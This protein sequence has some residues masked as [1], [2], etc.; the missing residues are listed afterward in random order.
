MWFV[1]LVT[2]AGMAVVGLV[3]WTQASSGP[4][5]AKGDPSRFFLCLAAVVI[6]GVAVLMHYAQ[7]ITEVREDGLYIRFQPFHLSFRR[8]PLENLR[9]FCVKSYS[10]LKDYGGYGIRYGIMGKAYNISGNSGVNFTFRK[11]RDML[12]GSQR[13]EELAASVEWFLQRRG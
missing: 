9:R 8:I 1:V 4:S 2:S 10:P 11:G 5:S 6:V 12:I 7:L 3:L 13:P